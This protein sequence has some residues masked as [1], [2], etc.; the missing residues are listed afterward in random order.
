MATTSGMKL[1]TAHVSHF[2]HAV[3]TVRLVAAIVVDR[4]C[5]IRGQPLLVAVRKISC[6]VLSKVV[7]WMGGWMD[8]PVCTL[9][10]YVRVRTLNA[11]KG[12]AGISSS[13]STAWLPS[14]TTPT[15][16]NPLT[17]P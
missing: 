10:S 15:P 7:G 3:G 8:G 2:S 6:P 1:G 17:T 16:V 12:V 14:R 4:L 9:K 11:S 5:Y 13:P